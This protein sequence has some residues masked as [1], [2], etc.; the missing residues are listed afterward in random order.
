[1][2][3]ISAMF[4][5]ASTFNQDISSWDEGSC[6]KKCIIH[7]GYFA[8]IP[9]TN[10]LV[11]GN[12]PIK[13][14][15]HAS[16]LANIPTANVLVKGTGFPKFYLKKQ[17]DI[18]GNGSD[19]DLTHWDVSHVSDASRAFSGL[20]ALF[21]MALL[22]LKVIVLAVV[23]VPPLFIIVRVGLVALSTKLPLAIK[24]IVVTPSL[25]GQHSNVAITVAANTFTDIVGNANTAI[26]KNTTQIIYLKKQVD[27][28]GNGSDVDLTK[29]IVLA[30]VSVPPLFIIVRVGLVAL[31]TK[32]PLAIKLANK[33]AL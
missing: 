22:K 33:S 28:N 18:D 10:I 25:G 15:R 27:I 32:L 21:L 13:H 8:N 14:P 9:I 31:S 1:M 20:T 24:L 2:T 11:K 12:C 5:I 3:N 4:H 23:S 19:V 16:R 6:H 30:V 29:V 26:T 7:S 17:V